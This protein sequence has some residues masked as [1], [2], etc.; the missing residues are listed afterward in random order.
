MEVVNALEGSYIRCDASSTCAS[1]VL[2]LALF[3]RVREL[4][5]GQTNDRGEDGGGGFLVV[6]RDFRVFQHKAR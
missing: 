6:S 5:I 3:V 4:I 1:Y 2:D